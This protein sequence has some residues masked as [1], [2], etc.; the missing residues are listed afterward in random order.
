M[1]FNK[2]WFKNFASYGAGGPE[3]VFPAD[4]SL[5][6]VQGLNG[7][8][9][10][11]IHNAMSF[12]L[13][14]KVEGKNKKDL[15]NRLNGGGTVV[16]GDLIIRGKHVVVERGI[17]PNFVNLTIDGVPYDKANAVIGPDEY[18][19]NEL[20]EIPSHVFNN[21]ICLSIKD[22][23]SFLKM[24]TKD[25][26]L[27]IDRIFAF[28][29]IMDMRDTLS[30]LQTQ[31]KRDLDQATAVLF[32]SKRSYDSSAAEL[33][34]LSEKIKQDNTQQ[35]ESLTEQLEQFRKLLEHHGTKSAAVL[36]AANSH[37]QLV[38]DLTKSL[39]A[40]D[41]KVSELQ[42]QLRLYS[43]S[44]CPTC[45]ADLNSDFHLNIKTGL[46]TELSSVSSRRDELQNNLESAKVLSAE[47]EKSKRDMTEKGAKIQSRISEI[48]SAMSKLKNDNIDEQLQSI[49]RIVERLSS[50][51]SETQT[52]ISDKET[53]S[54]WFKILEHALS[55]KGIKQ[56]AMQTIVP[57]FNSE[58]YRMM[59]E[60]HLSYS[61]IFDDQFDAKIMSMDQ[62]ISVSTLSS[63][64]V[65]KIDFVVLVSFLRLLKMKFPS[66]NVTFLDEIF[67]SVDQLGIHDIC[68]ILK[69]I[70][71]EMALNIFVVSHTPLP[72]QEFDYTIDVRKTTNF[73]SLTMNKL[74]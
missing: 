49:N 8:G 19:E 15:V 71:K 65:V 38:S 58:I 33:Q 56:L 37:A 25:K 46:E 24:S 10:S 43:N 30:K 17:S 51:I 53:K 64:E 22:F 13:Y 23:K 39:Y 27:L 63:G 5:F 69:R 16:G 55:D 74:S 70:A 52:S 50:E 57:A 6:L 54:A 4:P 62:E 1:K 32:A 31:V 44:Q 41:S 9:K 66:I 21:A 61:V 28:Q 20:L 42:R 72:V 3:I 45:S 60:M 18:L 11:T 47:Y 26:R 68:V 14:G 29:I 73:S 48:N 59:G 34:Q 35:V 67:A 12:L 40:V 7:G 36:S 2:I